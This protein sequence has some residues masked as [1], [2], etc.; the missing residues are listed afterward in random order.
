[1]LLGSISPKKKTASVV[2][3]VLI[4]TA[5]SPQRFV[6]A[7]VTIEAIE[8]CV[9]FVPIRI[10]VIALSNCSRTSSASCAFRFPLSESTFSFG[11]DAEASAVSATAK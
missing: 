10:V 9:I 11:R 5:F 2:R 8:R 4:E 6:T 1:M 7:T 3:I